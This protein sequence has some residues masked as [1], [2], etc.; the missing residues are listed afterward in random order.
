M[1]AGRLFHLIFR[2]RRVATG[3]V[4]GPPIVASRVKRGTRARR[5]KRVERIER[6]SGQG[7]SFGRRRRVLVGALG[8]L[9]LAVIAGAL[10]R[11]VMEGDFLR[12]EGERRYLRVR[13]I[14]AQ[15]G[16]ILD[17]NGEPL[18]VSTPVATVWG[19]P[20]RLVERPRAIRELAGALGMDAAG[21]MAQVRE[22][23]KRAFIYLKRRIGPEET[24][25]VQRIMDKYELPGLGLES[26]YR[27]FYPSGRIFGHVIGFTD[28][29]DR[30]IEGMEFA[31]DSW[32]RAEPG[33]R[34]IVQDGRRSVVAEVERIKSPRHGK[35]LTL[36]LD[37]RLQFLAYR[38]LARAVNKHRATAASVVVL[39]VT[40]GEVL[41]MVNQPAYN[42][43]AKLSGKKGACRNRALTDVMEP[44]STVKPF[45]VAAAL[46]A[47]LVGPHTQIDTSPGVLRVG[48]DRVRDLRNHGVLDT[49]GILT[50]S[51]NVGAVKL[52]MRM[53][54]AELW[55][56]YDR[57]GFGHPTRVGFP[58][59]TPGR[60]PH[61]RN[62]RTFER[63]TLAFGYG[64]SVTTLQLAQAYGVL[65]ADGVKR[66]VSLLKRRERPAAERI[67]S[68]ATA[69]KVRAMME[70]VV[71][72]KG[73]AKQA[74][75]AGYRVA[76]KTGTAK[77]AVRGGY[78]S[79]RYQA[80]FA[81]MV[82]A[83]RP[84]FVMVVMVDEPR[85]KHYYGGRVAAPVFAKVMEGA[86]RLFNVPPDDPDATLVLAGAG[87]LK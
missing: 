63:A 87:D 59:E 15:R 27:R 19:D 35:E 39:D 60:M 75:I 45:V 29:D 78:S 5:R 74:A 51:S 41:A 57:L 83:S 55:Q 4:L 80:V 11:Q 72:A 50:K 68:A 3:P 30:G 76:G 6:F 58:G 56:L 2:S 25:A 1:A 64:L 79:K 46:E 71:S 13:E 36:S 81:G 44:G 54:K 70:T 14:P 38:E 37:R 43:N 84:R 69:R 22:K 62:W 53:H 9:F 42:P 49:K 65:A 73:T 18:A 33:K 24:L 77:K 7:P 23:Q 34:R 61:F 12:N 32:L 82:P 20:R 40:S 16:M 10:E 8:V 66:P 47:G 28:V 17:R 52:A 85:G 21:L 26:E 31:F 86:L 48:R 67:F